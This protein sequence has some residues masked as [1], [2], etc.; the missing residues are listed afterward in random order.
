MATL[1]AVAAVVFGFFA[2]ILAI[3]QWNTNQKK[4]KA[5]LFQLR[6]PIFTE[7]VAFLRSTSSGEVTPDQRNSFLEAVVKSEFLY[8][9]EMHDYLEQLHLD[10]AKVGRGMTPQKAEI[11]QQHWKELEDVKARFRQHLDLMI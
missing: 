8:G 4:L 5:D 9:K 6:Y 1:T 10:G 2:T 7:T 3:Q 11:V